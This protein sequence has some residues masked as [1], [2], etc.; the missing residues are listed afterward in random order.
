MLLA[1]IGVACATPMR[2]FLKAE[3]LWEDDD[4]HPTQKPSPYWSP[5]AWDAAD[6]TAFRPL[7]HLFLL[8]VPGAARNVNALGEVPNSSWFS[9]RMSL[10]A[11]SPEEVAR[12]PCREPEISL[13]GP[14]LVKSGKVDGANP[15]FGIQDQ[16]T[17]QR[18]LLKFDSEEQKERATGADVIGSKIYW[19]AG[20]S[21]PCNR[22]IYFD[23]EILQ[24]APEASKKDDLGNKTPMTENDIE[25]ALRHAPRTE[26]GLVRGSA[27]LY[28]PGIPMG[29]FTYEGIRGDDP[30]DVVA[31]EDR[32]E[33]RG[34]RL[35]AAWLNHFDA[36]EQNTFTTFIQAKDSQ[37]GYLQH[38]LLDWGD[39]FGSLWP[40]DLMTRRF[41]HSYYL[42]FAHI[43]GDL[44]SLGLIERPWDRLVSYDDGPIFGYFDVAEFEPDAWQNGYPN[45][46][47]DRMDLVD[48][49]WAT[50]IISRFSDAHL[51]LLVAEA[52][53]TNPD[54]G[55]YL[56]RV[57]IGR[58]DAIV[59]RYF[60]L[61]SA[62]DAPRTGQGKVCFDDLMV[63]GGYQSPAD[64]YYHFR[65]ADSGQP[66]EYDARAGQICV[67]VPKDANASYFI[68]EG[69]IRRT[70]QPAAAKSAR[71]H[72]QR[73]EH[74]GLLLVGIER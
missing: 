39:C 49:F 66:L 34:S 30:N 47:F 19:A 40:S 27:S 53:F 43:L 73:I 69:S 16:A 41:G 61:L 33:L 31:H 64:S 20:F 5:L 72:L 35:L 68:I 45:E 18:Y 71:F 60:S 22:I 1:A 17:G 46:A 74:D 51:A 7:S 8:E 54:H 56:Q 42:D 55:D 44:L 28:L 50:K 15:G 32:R 36:R 58:R 57:L 48:A 12:G 25:Y 11:L 4:R 62:L 63:A 37:A 38:H 65:L 52:K 13:T 6:K 10:Q 70:E 24:L 23:R 14:W 9:N 29:P 3:I 26:E 21:T 59:R 2:P 67:S